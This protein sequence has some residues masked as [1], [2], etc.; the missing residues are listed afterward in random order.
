MVNLTKKQDQIYTPF[1]V[2]VKKRLIDMGLTQ[3]QLET[4]IGAPNN[5]LTM[6]LRGKRSGKKYI[7]LINA[8]LG[9]DLQDDL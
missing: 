2:A 7:P 3:G 9:M 1:G 8:Y 5:Y 4:G 6:V